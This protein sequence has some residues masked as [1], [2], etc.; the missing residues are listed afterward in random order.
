MIYDV[1]PLGKKPNW[2]EGL[3]VSFGED[4]YILLPKEQ[5]GTPHYPELISLRRNHLSKFA[6]I[7]CA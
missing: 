3:D 7:V 1:Y 6:S 5:A 2:E 4:K